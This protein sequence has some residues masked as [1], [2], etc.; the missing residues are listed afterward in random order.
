MRSL[1]RRAV[2]VSLFCFALVLLH[3]AAILAQNWDIPRYEA[4]VNLFA[5]GLNTP[6]TSGTA[7]FG[8]HFA[9]HH[10][11]FF[12]LE[13][14]VNIF[15]GG[16]STSSTTHPVEAFFG[17]RAGYTLPQAGVYLKLLPGFVHFQP[18]GDLP[19]AGLSPLTHFAF[20]LSGGVV[21]YSYRHTYFRF[22]VG[23]QFIFY[24]NRKILNPVTATRERLGTRGNIVLGIGFGIHF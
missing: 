5:L 22:D 3:P 13:S 14:N 11:R 10:N 19:Q 20:D 21:H 24:G 18:G 8:G 9:Y 15:N 17:P 12:G 7:G 1:V 6:V 16:G 23:S 4:G 2:S